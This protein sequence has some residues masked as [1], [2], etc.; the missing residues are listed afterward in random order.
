MAFL[1]YDLGEL[2][3]LCGEIY[4]L[5]K[6]FFQGLDKFVKLG[7]GHILA[8]FLVT[9]PLLLEPGDCLARFCSAVS[10]KKLSYLS[11]PRKR[12]SRLKTWIPHQVRDDKMLN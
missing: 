3:G 10:E 5:F 2:C 7:L 11:F 1:L 8:E 4:Y 12:E 6:F 9:E